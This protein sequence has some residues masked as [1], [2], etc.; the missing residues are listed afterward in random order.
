M[1]DCP[2]LEQ[3]KSFPRIEEFNVTIE[4]TKKQK[5]TRHIFR[6][7]VTGYIELTVRI[8]NKEKFQLLGHS[9]TLF[10]AHNPPTISDY[11]SAYMQALE[12]V[13]NG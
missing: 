10:Y 12:E 2:D 11:R 6:Y 3:A 8:H 5:L 1:T 7:Q 4:C 13:E 9:N